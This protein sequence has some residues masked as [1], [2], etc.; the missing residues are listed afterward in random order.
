MMDFKLGKQDHKHDDRTLMMADFIDLPVVPSHWDFDKNRRPFPVHMWGN[1]NFGD[2]VIA[3][4]ANSLLRMERIEQRRTIT[5]SD[6]DAVDRYKHLTGCVSAGDTN[7]TG[8]VMLDAFSNWRNE[9]FYRA[10]KPQRYFKIA[11]YGELD[12]ADQHQLHA[13]IYLLGGVHFGFALP[14]SAQAQ[15]N[16]GY[17][18]VVDH[19]NAPG[20]WGGHAVFSKRYDESN[21]YVETWKRTVRVTNAFVKKYCDEVWVVVDDIDRW[22]KVDH[23]DVQGLI[24]KLHSI[25]AKN[26]G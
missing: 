2:C 18:D 11:A 25:G 19:D 15:T 13:A 9:G 3:A 4:Q 8:L 14:I 22:R 1:D 20:S 23:L 10:E 5:L 17:W 24:A 12:P 7:D 6:K 26:I 16:K 21:V